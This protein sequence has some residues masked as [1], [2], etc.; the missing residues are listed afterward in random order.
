MLIALPEVNTAPAMPRWLGRRICTDSRPWPTSDQS[1]LVFSS[2]RNSVER[3]ALSRR[4]ASPIT[5]CSSEPSLMSAV[6][7]ETTSMNSISWRR[8]A[9]MRSMNCALC[10]ASVPWLVMAS[11]RF[12]SCLVNLPVRLFSV[13]ATPMISPLTVR[14]G[15]HRML[16]VVKPVCSSIE[17]LKRSSA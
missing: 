5:F 9:C 10:R 14:I 16:R 7:S 12:R 4:V 6:T 3:S 13:C 2:L 17:R 1:S 8:M 15:T 11:S